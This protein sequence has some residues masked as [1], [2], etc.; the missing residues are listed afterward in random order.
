MLSKKE[1]DYID[2][3]TRIMFMVI[4][5]ISLKNNNNAYCQF[6]K[7]LNKLLNKFG[8]Y[9]VIEDG[10]FGE[11][12]YEQKCWIYKNINNIKPAKKVFQSI[13]KK[14]PRY[15]IRNITLVSF[16]S[17]QYLDTYRRFLMFTK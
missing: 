17:H 13:Q 7:S 8:G 2:G 9:A 15:K 11:K 16:G 1:L 10:A 5:P 14:Y 12:G 4:I 6:G 3:I